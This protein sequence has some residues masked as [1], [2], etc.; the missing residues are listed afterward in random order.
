[1]SNV[2]RIDVMVAKSEFYSR[3]WATPAYCDYVNRE[4]LDV[5]RMHDFVSATGVIPII[6]CGRGRFEFGTMGVDPLGFV[7]EAYGPDGETTIDLVAWLLDNPGK[8]LSMF[9]RAAWLGAWAA[10]NPA[11]YTMGKALDVHKTP[12]DWLKTGC[13]GAAVVTPRLVA[14]EMMDLPGPIAARDGAH[15]RHL[16]ALAQST[17]DPNRIVV[18]RSRRSAA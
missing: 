13:S 12:L 4:G 15:G 7:C 1:M 8:V 2:P 10:W 5:D 18:P 9:G 16:L 3:A 14:R 11:T 6:D 17:F